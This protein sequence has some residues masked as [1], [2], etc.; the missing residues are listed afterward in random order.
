[1]DKAISR[2]I[3]FY[4]FL[5][6]LGIVLYHARA[7]APIN[8]AE[9][10]DGFLIETYALFTDQ[11]GFT[12]MS[13]FFFTSGFLL[14]Y[15]ASP[16]TIMRKMKTR[17]KSLLIP[18]IIWQVTVLLLAR[19]LW[20]NQTSLHFNPLNLF[21]RS[22]IAGPLWYC[23]ALLILMIPAP[24]LVRIKSKALLTI[25]AMIIIGHSLTRDLG[26]LFSPISFSHWWWYDNMIGY[27]LPYVL[28]CYIALIR[29]SILVSAKS[30]YTPYMLIGILLFITTTYLWHYHSSLLPNVIFSFLQLTAFWSMLNPSW[31]KADMPKFFD[32][33]FYIFALHQP[34]LIPLFNTCVI[35]FL[36]PLAPFANFTIVLL[37]LV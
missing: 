37:K 34:I 10:N 19:L 15:G 26:I 16:S 20:P 36:N 17:I 8:G 35:C 31:F 11:I 2:K 25:L 27:L 28:G 29:P 4:R 23:L 33:A 30:K 3:N 12:S 14:Y 18:F 24:I 9:N 5:F 21:F 1:M 13:F 32:C 7:L 6:T 22:P